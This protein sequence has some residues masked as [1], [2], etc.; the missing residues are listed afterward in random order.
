MSF[1]GD[2]G[3]QRVLALGAAVE[4]R[5]VDRMAGGPQPV[6]HRLPNP[7][8]LV[9]A[10]DQNESRHCV[11]SSFTFRHARESGYPGL[12]QW[13]MSLDP[14][15][16]GG[17]DSGTVVRRSRQ[18]PPVTSIVTPVTKSASLEARTQMT[19]A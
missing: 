14:R 12:P 17:D 16:R 18:F 3:A 15:F 8:A 2:A 7:A 5:R 4:A 10:V 13:P 6:C 11:I 9:R 1:G 19:L